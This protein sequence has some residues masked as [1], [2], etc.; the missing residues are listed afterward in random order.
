[1]PKPSATASS[2][3]TTMDE[4][5]EVMAFPIIELWDSGNTRSKSMARAM[6]A[7][8]NTCPSPNL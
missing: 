8:L 2:G 6:T 5:H 1:M 7:V 4:D 3:G